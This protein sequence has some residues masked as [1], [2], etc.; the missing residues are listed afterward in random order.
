MILAK[1]IKVKNYINGKWVDAVSKKTLK[2]INP[3][4]KKDV[5]AVV[6][7]SGKKDVD[8]AVK[9]ARKALETWRLTPAP[10][11]GEIL[12]KAAQL[13]LENKKRLGDLIVRE[14][15]K[16]KKESDG[17]VQEAIDIGYYFAA[18]G[19]KGWGQTFE[20]ELKNK[21]IRSIR[22]PVGVFA[23]ITPWNFPIAIPGWKLFPAL[24]YG[25]TVVFKPSNYTSACAFELVK[26]FEKAGVP[27]GVLNLVNGKGSEVGDML[28]KR[29]DIDAISFTGSTAVGKGIG[30]LCGEKLKPHSLEMGG[31]NPIIVMDDAKL[32]LAVDGC[33]WAGFGTTG[34]R[35]TAGSRVIVHKKIFDKF[36]KR[37]V[38]R[39]KKLKL[40]P[41]NKKGID[42]GPLINEEQLK[43]VDEYVRIGKTK[44]KAKLLCG[45]SFCKTGSC[46]DG[47]FYQPTVFTNVA[48]DMTIAQEEIF[49]PVVALIKADNLNDA[50]KKANNI[51]YGLSS[52]IFTQDINNAEIAARDLRAGLV[53]INTST[54]GAEIQTPF[55]GLKG[56]G[57]GHREAGGYGGAIETYTE[58]KVIS[59][60]FSGKLQKAQMD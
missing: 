31:K 5:V 57:N 39:V 34:Q 17:D 6:P 47:F 52:A 8:N 44:D 29:K 45:G 27:E 56:T 11:R 15:G 50:I 51:K 46:R 1:S 43:K 3:A 53:Y 41:G 48:T 28:V 49:G 36:Q 38:A 13:L 26:I 32:D 18:E 35:C 12:F 54:I 55:G 2:S 10:E 16:V 9:A 22:Q 23:C 59:T 42:V 37:F 60:D 24:V 30:K 21:S 7:R 25:N 33:I 20:S 58:L 4:D 14:M 19:R 40:G